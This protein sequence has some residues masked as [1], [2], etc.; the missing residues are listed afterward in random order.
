VHA[1][2]AFHRSANGPLSTAAHGKLAQL[3]KV[4][5]MQAA[6]QDELLQLLPKN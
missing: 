6:L 4:Q 1:A 5:K 3:Y 2:A